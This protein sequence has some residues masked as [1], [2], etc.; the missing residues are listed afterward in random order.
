M[1]RYF[2][3]RLLRAVLVIIAV[4][5]LSFCLFELAPGDFFDEL[6]LDP[7]TKPDYRSASEAAWSRRS[8]CRTICSVARLSGPRRMGLFGRLQQPRWTNAVRACAEHVDS[9]SFGCFSELGQSRFRLRCGQPTAANGAA[10]TNSV[11]S[12][13]LSLPELVVLLA[14]LTIAAQWRVL[15]AGGMT[16]LEFSG[17]SLGGKIRDLIAHLIAP[18]DSTSRV[19]AAFV[20]SAHPCSTC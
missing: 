6:R 8:R 2:G 1:M 19:R 12:L 17:M 7:S 13:L 9:H 4:S 20:D 14:L 11:V 10:I 16:S 3:R 5:A 15:P 18:V